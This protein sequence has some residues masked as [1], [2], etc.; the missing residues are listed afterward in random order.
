MRSPHLVLRPFGMLCAMLMFTAAPA[1]LLTQNAQTTQYAELPDTPAV[2]MEQQQS[3]KPHSSPQ[4]PTQMPDKAENPP[5]PTPRIATWPEGDALSGRW[6]GLRSALIKRGIEPFVFYTAIGSG[7]PRGGYSQGH[8]TAVDDFYMGVRLD[9]TTLVHW[10]G[11]TL[12]ISGV[13]RDGR[14]L[15]N[16]YI[17]SQYNVQQTVGGQSLFFYQLVLKQKF[18]H[19]HMFF[20]I[21]RFSASDD[22][23]ASPIYGLYV[24][25]GI[26]GDIRNVLFDTQSSAYPFSTW[27]ALY[28]GDFKHGVNLQV[29]VYQTWSDIFN[30]QTNGVDWTFHKGDGIMWRC[31]NSASQD[32]PVKRGCLC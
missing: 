24:N 18:D 26:D 21:G 17:K 1:G 5:A 7:N 6:G 19:D 8:V 15:T 11:A 13:N 30:S 16:E 28:R 4:Q 12:T 29:G 25:N 20:K 22:L 23:N 32:T 2:D 9:L 3:T 27:A 31:L 14:G 10:P